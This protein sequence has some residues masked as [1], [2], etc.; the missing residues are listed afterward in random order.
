MTTFKHGS[1]SMTVLDT[2]NIRIKVAPNREYNVSLSEL[3]DLIDCGEKLRH[4]EHELPLTRVGHT[5]LE[6]I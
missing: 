5:S 4:N 2:S 1:V 6:G 3:N